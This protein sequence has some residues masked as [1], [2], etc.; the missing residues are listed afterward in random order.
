L[1]SARV[2]KSQLSDSFIKDFEKSKDFQV[3]SVVVCRV[4]SVDD[5]GH[6]ELSLRNSCVNGSRNFEIFFTFLIFTSGDSW[7]SITFDDIEVN[8]T[9]NGYVKSIQSY[10]IFVSFERS[11]V[12]CWMILLFSDKELTDEFLVG[13]WVVSQVPSGR[14]DFGRE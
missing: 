1:I 5:S 10:G 14:A 7:K 2:V 4:L 9:Y 3:G 8:K 11:K 6:V 12:L 13:F